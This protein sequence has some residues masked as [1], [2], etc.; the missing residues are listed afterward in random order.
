MNVCVF[1][2]LF[3][4]WIPTLYG[5]LQYLIW[6]NSIVQYKNHK[7]SKH[8][9]A[10]WQTTQEYETQNRFMLAWFIFYIQILFCKTIYLY[11]CQAEGQNIFSLMI[12][13]GYGR[14]LQNYL[15]SREPS[16]GKVNFGI[17]ITKWIEIRRK[18][19]WIIVDK[20]IK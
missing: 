4:G 17:D 6:M 3:W 7:A 13:D 8:D 18:R 5:W 1:I 16:T 14:L 9:L 19:N 12:V 2:L 20:I 10:C 11:L 15:Y